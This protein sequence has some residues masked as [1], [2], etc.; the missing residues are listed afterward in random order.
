MIR[1][2]H[3]I[4]SEAL[5]SSLGQLVFCSLM[6]QFAALLNCFILFFKID[7]SIIIAVGVVDEST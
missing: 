4:N 6:N 3:L 1:V 7:F 2:T 5:R